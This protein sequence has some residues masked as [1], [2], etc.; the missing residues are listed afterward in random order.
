MKVYAFEP[1][2]FAAQ[3]ICDSME[4]AGMKNIEVMQVGLYKQKC[5]LEFQVAGS[6]EIHGAQSTIRLDW[7]PEKGYGTTTIS[8]MALDDF[9]A[10]IN[11][12]KIRFWKLDVE[13]SEYEALR[14]AGKALAKKAIDFLF[15]EISNPGTS[16]TFNFLESL[17]YY[18]HRIDKNSNLILLR[19]EDVIGADYVSDFVSDYVFVPKS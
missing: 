11:E 4:I 13:G 12:K 5:E 9:L 17:G 3:W 15:V 2:E 10:S 18:P 19:S 6:P 7:Y 14:G 8:V 1:L 16:P